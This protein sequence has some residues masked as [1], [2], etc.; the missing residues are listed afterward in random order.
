MNDDL[1]AIARAL[2]ERNQQIVD[3]HAS[4][5]KPTA[6]ASEMGC[7]Y[8]VVTNVLKRHSRRA[9]GTTR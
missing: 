8:N 7:G 5:K 1:I 6:I 3:L 2:D 9:A 4:G